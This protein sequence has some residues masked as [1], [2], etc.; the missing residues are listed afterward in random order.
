MALHDQPGPTANTGPRCQCGSARR[1]RS[2]RAHVSGAAQWH[3]RRRRGSGQLAVRHS[4]TARAGV[5]GGIGQGGGG[6]HSPKWCGTG[7]GVA[8]ASVTV[9][10]VG[11]GAPV[12]LIGRNRVLGQRE[13]KKGVGE[14]FHLK[15]N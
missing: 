14:G 11:G 5:A 4:P 2:P 6:R 7:G 8:A 15:R 12:Y 1:A 9:F 10:P 13:T 3:A